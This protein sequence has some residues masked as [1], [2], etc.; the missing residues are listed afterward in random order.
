MLLLLDDIDDW[1]H[2]DSSSRMATTGIAEPFLMSA[3]FH[4]LRG[5]A[6]RLNATNN[7]NNNECS[8]RRVFVVA[9]CTRLDD[10]PPECLLP[11]MWGRHGH[12]VSISNPDEWQRQLL[13]EKTLQLMHI[14]LPA[15][16]T[17]MSRD[18][19]TRWRSCT[20][21]A[22]GKA[23][24]DGLHAHAMRSTLHHCMRRVVSTDNT[25]VLVSRNTNAGDASSSPS[26]PLLYL[27]S[28]ATASATPSCLLNAVEDAEVMVMD[29]MRAE[30]DS[31]S[32][33]RCNPLVSY[34]R[35]DNNQSGGD[36]LIN[37]AA[38]QDLL[39]RSV[40][41]PMQQ[42]QLRQMVD[43]NTNNKRFVRAIP[44]CSGILIHGGSGTGKTA[45]CQWL[46][47]QACL[48]FV[49]VSCADLVHKAVGESERAIADIFK[50]AR[51]VAPC[52]LLLDN[53]EMIVGMTSNSNGTSNKRSS[54]M[55][56]AALDRILST[57]LAEIDGL[58]GKSDV[59]F[60]YQQGKTCSSSTSGVVVVA[61]TSDVHLIER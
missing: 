9:T 60:G 49:S 15:N 2:S 28:Q 13:I 23:I 32:L 42:N 10:C 55:G 26:T 20:V 52:F 44:C 51:N 18:L 58:A 40:I 24:R 31:S 1:G 35:H 43:G 7:N 29:L 16:A 59:I 11:N 46:V 41:W 56:H 21:P 27:L 53:I 37:V 38:Q 8:R 6:T 48:P 33:F 14:P 25:G 47:S 45:L 39:R 4:G 34:D 3:I 22:I 57:L 61:T 17:T 5:I 12:I 54:R 30:V 36:E 50:A 19:A